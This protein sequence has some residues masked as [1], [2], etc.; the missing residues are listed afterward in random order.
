MEDLPAREPVLGSIRQDLDPDQ[1][2]KAVD[3]ADAP[4]DQTS[5]LAQTGLL[6][7]SRA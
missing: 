2:A 6:R 1:A 7:R 5:G 3:A 4:D